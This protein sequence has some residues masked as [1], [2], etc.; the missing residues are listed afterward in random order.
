MNSRYLDQV[1]R[2]LQILPHVMGEKVFA[3]KGGTAINFFI[4]DVPRLSVD[5]DLVYTPVQDRVTSLSEISTALLRIKGKIL[6]HFGKVTITEKRIS[7]DY[8]IKLFVNFESTRV[9]VEP[10]TILRGTLYPI[11][12]RV[13]SPA[14]KELVA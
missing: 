6:S 7:G 8:C 5:I 9:I 13:M 2:M 3:L 11:K 14:I 1:G 12:S 4:R 10:N